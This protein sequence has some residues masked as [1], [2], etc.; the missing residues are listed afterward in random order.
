MGEKPR[1]LRY[2]PCGGSFPVLLK[3]AEKYARTWSE[4]WRRLGGLVRLFRKGNED[5]TRWLVEMMI[6]TQEFTDTICLFNTHVK[7]VTTMRSSINNIRI[8]Y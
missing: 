3:E 7:I 8:R 6:D 1:H 2:V 5:R 4:M